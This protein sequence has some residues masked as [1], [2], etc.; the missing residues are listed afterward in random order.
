MGVK[1]HVKKSS[2][3]AQDLGHLEIIDLMLALWVEDAGSRMERR[4]EGCEGSEN[5]GIL[6]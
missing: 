2:I 5:E 6:G 3:M 4:K 1:G